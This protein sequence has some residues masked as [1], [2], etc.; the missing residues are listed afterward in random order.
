MHR[1][2]GCKMMNRR[3]IPLTAT[4]LTVGVLVTVVVLGMQDAFKQSEPLLFL[5]ALS[6]ATFVAAIL[7][8]GFGLLAFVS[9]EGVFDMLAFGIKTLFRSLRRHPTE[10][11]QDYY[12]YL[13]EKRKS[14]GSFLH[15]LIA[16]AIFLALAILLNLILKMVLRAG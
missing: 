6:N 4:A 11:R 12:T 13:Q 10:G 15:L 7:L 3:R 9:K 5:Q 2:S 1:E 8:L 16:G 14:R